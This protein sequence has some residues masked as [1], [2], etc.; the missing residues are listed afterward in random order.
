MTYSSTLF[1]HFFSAQRPRLFV[2]DSGQTFGQFAQDCLAADLIINSVCLAPGSGVSVSLPLLLNAS[3]L[4]NDTQDRD[5]LGELEII[6][7]LLITGG[8]KR[9]D[10]RITRA[11]RLV[12]RRSILEAK[13]TAAM[14][15][16][17]CIVPTEVAAAMHRIAALASTEHRRSIAEMAD[18]L[19]MFCSGPAGDLFNRPG[20][21]W[22][23]ADV[24]VVD[25][26]GLTRDGF[27]DQLPIAL[28]GLASIISDL[29]E[30][31]PH[32]GRP[33]LVCMSDST[34]LENPLLVTHFAA[35][36]KPWSRLNCSLWLNESDSLITQVY[37]HLTKFA[38]TNSASASAGTP[39]SE[40]RYRN[41][42][43]SLAS[44]T[45]Q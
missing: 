1:S 32:G 19:E 4:G 34:L 31:E 25:V 18:A 22:H 13:T 37:P 28:V 42:N 7:R 9:E 38:L 23:D 15:G 2:I 27:E 17:P 6:T 10:D 40:S 14:V 21:Y 8:E 24:T 36:T 44:A 26:S 45:C 41:K 12:I 43:V 35:M 30:N 33:T 20:T 3:M 11:D 5:Y 39:R 29:A 16:R